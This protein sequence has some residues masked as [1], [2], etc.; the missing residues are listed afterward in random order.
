M[1]L[2]QAN[3]RNAKTTK[4]NVRIEYLSPALL[5][6]STLIIFE[7]SLSSRLMPYSWPSWRRMAWPPCAWSTE[8]SIF[9]TMLMGTDAGAVKYHSC[10]PSSFAWRKMRATS[11]ASSSSLARRNWKPWDTYSVV[12]DALEQQEC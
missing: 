3:K 9:S 1:R 5:G 10:L 11:D 6:I 8:I 2:E 12:V 7:V 4:K